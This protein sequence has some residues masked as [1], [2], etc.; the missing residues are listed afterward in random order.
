MRKRMHKVMLV[1]IIVIIVIAIALLATMKSLGFSPVAKASITYVLACMLVA[2]VIL[3]IVFDAMLKKHV[4]DGVNRL[5][6]DMN[7]IA[8]GNF[9]VV[10]YVRGN[11]EFEQMSRGINAMVRNITRTSGM[12]SRVFEMMDAQFAVFEYNDESMR[13]TTTDLLGTLLNIPPDELGPLIMDRTQ[14]SVR[15][16][17]LTKSPIKGEI[18]VYQIGGTQEHPRYV[19]INL[20]QDG[21]STFGMVADVTDE[22][23]TKQNIMRERDYD[24]LTKIRNRR[25]FERDVTTLLNTKNLTEGAMIM[26]DLDKFKMINDNYGH[27]FGDEYLQRAAG[28]IQRFSKENCI[29]AR[30]SGDEFYLV[31]YGCESKDQIRKMA[32]DYFLMLKN[33]PIDFPD[34][35]KKSIGMSLGIAWYKPGVKDFDAFLKCADEALYEAKETG[36]NKYGE[37]EFL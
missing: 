36:R 18:D 14:F 23:R 15:I 34:G 21:N 3:S 32:D 24:P 2:F 16:A 22:I 20:T 35:T 33:E 11:E 13:V 7:R 17:W 26:I 8:D 29:V 10:S 9:D 37:R 12:L 28:F 31:V 5:I 6:M 1:V 25:S 30:R 4:V 27:A 19:R